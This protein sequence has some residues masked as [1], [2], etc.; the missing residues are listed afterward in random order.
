MVGLPATTEAMR[1]G[2]SEQRT[3]FRA[4]TVTMDIL[5]LLDVDDGLE[6]FVARAD[7]ARAGF[8]AAL[9]RDQLGELAGQ[10]DVG[11]FQ[12]AADERAAAAGARVADLGRAG[13]LGG[14][15]QV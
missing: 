14:A 1:S 13:V 11:A 3:L 6:N 2:R 8:E 10:V 7:D 15:E 5:L 9:V 12:G 4:V